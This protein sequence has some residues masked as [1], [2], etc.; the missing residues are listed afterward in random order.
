MCLFFYVVHVIHCTQDHGTQT[1]KI[2][3]EIIS[4]AGLN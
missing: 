1:E 4:V 3:S 2:D